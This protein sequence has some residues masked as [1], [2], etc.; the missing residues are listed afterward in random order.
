MPSTSCVQV[1]THAADANLSCA[2]Q[3]QVRF[4]RWLARKAHMLGLGIGLKN[5]VGLVPRLRNAFDW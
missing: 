2:M 5:A 3:D 1:Q 4:N